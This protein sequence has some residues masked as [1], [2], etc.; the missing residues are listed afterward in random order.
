MRLQHLVIVAVTSALVGWAAGTS[1]GEDKQ[2]PSNEEILKMLEALGKPGP[3]HDHILATEGSW[4]VQ[5]RVWE[6]GAEPTVSTARSTA[7]AIMGGRFVRSEY[8][9]QMFGRPYKTIGLMGYN[10]A[11]KQ[12]EAVWV[13]DFNSNI[14]FT[15]GQAS[16]D[17]KTITFE[18]VWEGPNDMKSPYRMVYA[19]SRD[20][21]TVTSFARHGGAEVKEMELV[22]KRTGAAPTAMPIAARR[23]QVATTPAAATPTPKPPAA[24]ATPTPTP[25]PKATP[26]PSRFVPCPPTITIPYCE[27]I[28]YCPP[29]PCRP[30]W[31]RR[32]R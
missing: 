23:A 4:S 14:S 20:G 7:Q 29:R 11:K 9:G 27:P 24:A 19:F 3:M 10:N 32:C 26:V 30:R 6:G 16:P 17:G 12:Y 13:D 8:E 21:Y 28:P 1:F 15:I 31:V 18:G 2:Q 5:A 25:A 22:Y